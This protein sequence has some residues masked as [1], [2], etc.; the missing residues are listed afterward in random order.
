MLNRSLLKFIPAR[1]YQYLNIL[2]QVNL[3]NQNLAIPLDANGGI[4][5]IFWKKLWRAEVIK[6]LMHPSDGVF[7]DV[8]ANIGQTLLDLRLTHPKARYIGFEPNVNCVNYLQKLIQ[9]NNL[10]NYL[11]IPVG[12]SEANQVLPL[13]RQQGLLI[14]SGGT[15]LSNL[16]P[17]KPCEV[18]F[19]PCFRF[20]DVWQTLKINDI[21]FVKIDVEGAELEALIGMKT[22]LQEYRPLIL[23]EVLFTSADADL[24]AQKLRNDQ[25]MQLLTNMNYEVF[26]LIKSGDETRIVDT[27]KV[28][29]FPSAYWSMENQA[30]CDYL[31]IPEEKRAQALNGLLS[32][33]RA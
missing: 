5:N 7:I 32:G 27:K 4:E 23:C 20:D 6:S 8:G 22:S 10:Q 19:V 1:F 31:F 11:I 14:D 16:R 15:I 17:Q 29:G 13:Y 21:D 24:S 25:L 12:L 26:Q 30:L 2:V 28:E 3:E 18:D 33:R 9:S